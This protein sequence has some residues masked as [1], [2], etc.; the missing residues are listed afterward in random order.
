[1]EDP[2]NMQDDVQRNKGWKAQIVSYYKSWVIFALAW[3]F[4]I[5]RVLQEFFKN[6]EMKTEKESISSVNGD[7]EKHTDLRSAGEI[8]VEDTKVRDH[9]NMRN[10][11]IFSHA[12]S[13]H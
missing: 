6:G 2:V 4:F 3:Y 8:Q 1:M 9:I 12:L 7:T 5:L 13:V 11:I 10:I